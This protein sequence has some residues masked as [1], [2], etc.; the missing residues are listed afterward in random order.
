MWEKLYLHGGRGPN[1]GGSREMESGWG[2]RSGGVCTLPTRSVPPTAKISW[3]D[4]HPTLQKQRQDE[5]RAKQ[6]AHR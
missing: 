6:E 3:K 4:Q 1:K 5:L 2:Q